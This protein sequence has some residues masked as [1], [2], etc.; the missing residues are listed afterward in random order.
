MRLVL[1]EKAY[2]AKKKAKE[3]LGSKDPFNKTEAVN[4]ER[5][6]Y[7]LSVGAQTSNSAHN[8]LVKQGILQ[9][10]KIAVHKKSKKEPVKAAAEPAGQPVAENQPV[11]ESDAG[12]EKSAEQP[13]DG[14]SASV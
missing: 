11:A 5:V 7:W 13:Q 3:I 8:F 6:K 4:A 14:E 1:T 10:P 12:A 9:A 2:S